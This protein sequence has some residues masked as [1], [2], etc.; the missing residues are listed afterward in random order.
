MTRS[1]TKSFPVTVT[2]LPLT[3]CEICQ[4]TVAYRPGAASA[5]LTKHYELRHKDAL[6]KSPEPEDGD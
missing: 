5:A 2:Q 6:G 3:R 4:T 1:A